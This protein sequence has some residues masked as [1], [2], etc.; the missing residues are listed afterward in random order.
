MTDRRI[1][2]DEAARKVQETI[3]SGKAFETFVK[4][5]EA[6]GGDGSQVRQPEKLPTAAKVVPLPSPAAG[7]IARIDCEEIGMAAM[8]LGA[9]RETKESVIDMAVGLELLRHVGDQVKAGEPLAQVHIDPKR[10]N[11]SALKRLTA[12]FTLTA[13]PVKAQPL[14]LD[15]VS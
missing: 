13:E 5:V 4:M 7:S 1:T 14:I 9:G 10:N 3:S 8:M 6:Q 12:A 15:I 2:K 11:E